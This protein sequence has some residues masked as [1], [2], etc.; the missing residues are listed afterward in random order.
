M[1]VM[2]DFICEGY[3]S[4]E[5]RRSSDNYKMKNSYQQRDS[6]LVPSAYELNALTIVLRDLIFIERLKVDHFYPQ[7][8]NKPYM[9]H[10][11]DVVKCFFVYYILNSLQS[12]NV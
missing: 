5:E 6:N 11:V 12:A 4:C 10:V 7:Y 1:Y 8:A 3:S 9:N 2:F